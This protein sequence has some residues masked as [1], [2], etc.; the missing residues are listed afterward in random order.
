VER[1]H[2]LRGVSNLNTSATATGQRM[3]LPH[4][5]SAAAH[6]LHNFDL[7]SW[8]QYSIGPAG[9]FDDPA[10]ELDGDPRGVQAELFEQSQDRLSL[11]GRAG[12]AV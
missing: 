5:A 10:V 4:G 6:E 3:A 9:L 8:L 11:R 12:F 7:R 2:A 1:R